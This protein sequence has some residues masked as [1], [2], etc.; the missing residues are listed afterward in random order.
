MVP[1]A[2]KPDFETAS[3][4]KYPFLMCDHHFF[5]FGGKD[6]LAQQTPAPYERKKFIRVVAR[7]TKL[8]FWDCF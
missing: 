6:I 1:I 4:V 2:Q 7:A 3:G 5:L 8:N